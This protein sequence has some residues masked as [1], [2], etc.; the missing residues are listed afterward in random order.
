MAHLDTAQLQHRILRQEAYVQ[1]VA[2]AATAIDV[3]SLLSVI[4]SYVPQVLGVPRASIALV[5]SINESFEVVALG[6]KGDVLKVGERVPLRG[7][8]I[9]EAVNQRK[10]ISTSAF[11]VEAFRDWVNLRQSQDLHQFVISPLVTLDGILGTLNMGLPKDAELGE[12]ELL[13]AEQ[14][15]Q[16][17]ATHLRVHTALKDL[18]QSMD[19]LRHAQDI[20]VEQAKLAA[21]GNLVAGVAH[22]VNTPLGVSITASSIISSSLSQMDE[23]L[24]SGAVSRR[25]LKQQISRAREGL[26]LTEANLNR[27]ATLIGEFKRLAVDQSRPVVSEIDVLDVVNNLVFSLK[28][29][30]KD[31]NIQ[32]QISGNP[33]HIV[34]ESSAIQQVLTNL[35]Q[36]ACI[37][38]Y[39][40][41]GGNI[42]ITVDK[43]GN[44]AQITIEDHGIG[45]LPAIRNR[46]FEPFFTTRRGE[47]GT[48]LGLY[49]A[50]NLMRGPLSG[51][52]T[53]ASVL[54]EGTTFQL[55]IANQ[56]ETK[57]ERL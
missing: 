12:H 28:P 39:E 1:L 7:T 8:A 3:D 51:D 40:E 23:M 37:H 50:Q 9:E 42:E 47:G 29:M 45:M 16:V 57:G 13:Q 54:G 36:N 4:S 18:R 17:I 2:K 22:E 21:L 49:I 27:A 52:I 14:F 35:I 38:A 34:S 48:G 20:L 41:E 55:T 15:A 10:Q 44:G 26:T 32:V 6:G 31:A 24:Q 30:T 25:G 5:D 46:I 56:L 11:P 33:L 19:N 43:V 53:V